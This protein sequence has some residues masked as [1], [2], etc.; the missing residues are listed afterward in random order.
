MSRTSDLS[1]SPLL[2]QLTQK[3]ELVGKTGSRLRQYP[4]STTNNLV[5]L[6]NL[7]MALAPETTLEV[8][9]ATGGSAIAITSSLRDLGCAPSGQHVAIDPFQTRAEG[10]GYDSVGLEHLRLEGL[11][12]YLRFVGLPSSVALPNLLQEGLRVDFAY[13]DGSHLF[14]DVFVD[15]YFAFKMLTEGGVVCFDDCTFRD[16]RKVIRFIRAN[17]KG[18]LEEIDLRSY[19]PADGFEPK[20]ALARLAGRVQLRAFRRVGPALRPFRAPLRD[21]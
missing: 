9:L 14:E 16:V 11:D 8:G 18:H 19:R 15:F 17:L 7:C 12:G 10:T 6:R 1:F 5:T 21:F 3:K 20:Y 4:L 2:Q 13:I